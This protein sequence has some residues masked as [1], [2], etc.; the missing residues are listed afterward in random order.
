MANIIPN[1]NAICDLKCKYT[2][3]YKDMNAN[4][5]NEKYKLNIE[6]SYDTK[7]ISEPVTYNSDK[8]DITRLFLCYPSSN[9][10]NGKQADAELYLI[11]ESLTGGYLVVCIPIMISNET[12]K[13][14]KILGEVIDKAYTNSLI[15][16]YEDRRTELSN[17]INLN[18]LVPMKKY[19][20]DI[21]KTNNANVIIFS[22]DDTAYIN[23]KQEHY[24]K[25]KKTIYKLSGSILNINDKLYTN[26]NGPTISSN[27]VEDDIYIDCK[28]Y[29]EDDEIISNDN[30]TQPQTIKYTPTDLN[31]STINSVNKSKTFMEKS[32]N[33]KLKSPLFIVFF[34]I[35]IVLISVVPLWGIF[36]IYKNIKNKNIVNT[37]SK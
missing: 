13:S 20:A 11:H 33:E 15:K 2:F 35:I 23:I 36:T 31:N 4:I 27:N 34:I 9:K 28:P 10:Y 24:E 18:E 29:T 16:K 1:N 8:Y 3:N 6:L 14:S 5:Y 12:S 19:Y 26:L 21:D 32:F 7:N 30:T 37:Q 22:I 25:L 17:K